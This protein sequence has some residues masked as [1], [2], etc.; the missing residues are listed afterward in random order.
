M[1]NS[2]LILI[3]FL[4]RSIT[5]AD[6]CIDGT[7]RIPNYSKTYEEKIHYCYNEKGALYTPSCNDLEN[8]IPVKIT[9]STDDLKTYGYGTPGSR[10][11]YALKGHAQIVEY[12]KADNKTWVKASR[13]VFK[14]NKF[15]DTG[16][17][18]KSFQLPQ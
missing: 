8:C 13:C 15:V 3:I 9:I 18:L 11:C 14:N 1:K 10:A 2:S 16:T 7:I 4:F 5:Y 17:V 12:L 6:T